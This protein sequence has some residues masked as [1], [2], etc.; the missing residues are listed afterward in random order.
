MWYEDPKSDSPVGVQDLS[1]GKNKICIPFLTDNIFCETWFPALSRDSPLPSNHPQP[2]FRG[3]L[4]LQNADHVCFLETKKYLLLYWKQ[5]YMRRIKSLQ[6]AKFENNY[7]IKTLMWLRWNK[8]LSVD[9]C[10]LWLQT[11][12]L[13]SLYNIKLAKV[14]QHCVDS[15]DF[16]FTFLRFLKIRYGVALNVQSLAG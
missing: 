4:E 11:I 7:I 12:R 13:S 14:V 5:F 10:T 2:P 16:F 3:S 15:W 6:T 1:Y 9:L 8:V